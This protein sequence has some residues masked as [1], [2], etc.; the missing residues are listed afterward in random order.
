MSNKELIADSL[1][2]YRDCILIAQRCT[3]TQDG[4]QIQGYSFITI[5]IGGQV[6][7]H[8][9]FPDAWLKSAEA[10]I[11][12]GKIQIDLDWAKHRHCMVE[13]LR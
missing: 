6:T 1:I 12:V 4:V 11:E 7:A 8:C 10:A 5:Y 9:T 2:Y 13:F 3:S